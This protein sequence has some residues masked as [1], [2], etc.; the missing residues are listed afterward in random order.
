MYTVYYIFSRFGNYRD[1][2]IYLT[3]CA[4]IENNV[5]LCYVCHL[6]RKRS[7]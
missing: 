2:N 4:D 5:A 1:I 6:D 7:G 3:V